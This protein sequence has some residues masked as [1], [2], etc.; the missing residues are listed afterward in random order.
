M[1]H[2]WLDWVQPITAVSSS[3]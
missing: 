1:L 3:H 2:Y